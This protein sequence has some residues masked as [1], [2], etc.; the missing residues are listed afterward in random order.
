LNIRGGP[1]VGYEK[2]DES[3]L[4]ANTELVKLDEEGVWIKVNL[5]GDAVVIGW[6]HSGYVR[7]V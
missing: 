7:L 3:P 5:S 1:G 2:L 4:A 6:V